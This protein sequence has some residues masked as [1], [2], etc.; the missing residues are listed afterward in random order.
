VTWIAGVASIETVLARSRP[1]APTWL[2]GSPSLASRRR[3]PITEDVDHIPGRTAQARERV[4]APR[5]LGG[6]RLCA[7]WRAATW[8]RRGERTQLRGHL[9]DAVTHCSSA[10]LGCRSAPL[11]RPTGLPEDDRRH[12][13]RVPGDPAPLP[14]SGR[15]VS[16]S[17]P[18]LR[19]H[20]T[21]PGPSRNRR[22]ALGV[23]AP[24]W[25]RSL[26]RSLTLP[27]ARRRL[28]GT[29]R[30]AEPAVQQRGVP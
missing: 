15:S 17:R 2:V 16:N 28:R 8:V 7:L 11:S 24:R 14:R 4:T 25:A 20:V 13:R 3:Q 21:R 22:N 23:A 30:G 27:A 9:H 10:C 6:P 19:E 29:P 5:C 18:W 1:N 26:A 12:G